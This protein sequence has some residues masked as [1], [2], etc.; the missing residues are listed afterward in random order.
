[1]VRNGVHV[2]FDQWDVQYGESLTQ[3][4]EGKLSASDFVLIICTPSYA[5]KSTAR[6][7]GVGYEAQIISARIAAS[8]AR[9]RFV[10]ILRSGDLKPDKPDCSV[11]PHFQGILSI[12]MRDDAQFDTRFESLL[13][14]VYGVPAVERP[15]LG[16]PPSFAV[17]RAEASSDYETLR[18]AHFEIEHWELQSGVARSELY[19]A[20]FHIPDAA[21]RR[22]LKQGDVVKLMFEYVYP[23][24]CDEEDMCGGERMWVEITGL[25]GPY[26]VGQLRNSPICVADWHDLDFGSEVIFLPEHVIDVED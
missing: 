10:P 4:M 19:P 7:G 11:P 25:R 15:P 1:M 26:F 21:I 22:T 9:S 23:E 17:E 13:R 5:M 16:G 20:T 14:H 2:H 12:D 24:D 8:L 18:L 3:F 6:Q